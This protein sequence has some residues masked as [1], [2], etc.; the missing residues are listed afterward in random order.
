MN[1][2]FNVNRVSVEISGTSIRA[3]RI[4]LGAPAYGFGVPREIV[5]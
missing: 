5:S 1:Q 3:S 4:G 2:A